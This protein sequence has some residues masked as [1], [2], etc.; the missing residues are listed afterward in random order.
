MKHFKDH[1]IRLL[2]V[3]GV[4][5]GKCLCAKSNCFAQGKHP[6]PFVGQQNHG[7]KNA[8]R[9]YSDDDFVG[10]NVGV[11]CGDGLLVV[12][13]DPR[14]N[15]HITWTQLTKGIELPQTWTVSTGGGG[16]HIY[17]RVP[18][19]R[20]IRSVSYEGVDFQYD[21]KYVIA[22]PSTHITGQTYDWV[23]CEPETEPIADCPKEILDWLEAKARRLEHTDLPEGVTGLKPTPI[24]A[25]EIRR[26]LDK[27]SPKIGYDNWLGVGMG[28][29]A[30]GLPNAFDMWD[31]WSR[32]DLSQYREGETRRKWA[33]FGKDN[34]R[35]YRFIFWLAELYQIESDNDFLSEWNSTPI[36]PPTPA[37][38]PLEHGYLLSSLLDMALDESFI[39]IEEFALASAL[40]ILSASVQGSYRS[41]TNAPLALY[42]WCAAPAGFGK[43]SYVNFTKSVVKDIHKALLP[44][45]FGSVGGLRSCLLAF[46]SI[47]CVKDEWHD[48]FLSFTMSHNEYA[49]ALGQDYKILYNGPLELDG[50]AIKASIQPP[51]SSPMLGLL[52]FSTID[53]LE[54]CAA[55]GQ[56]LVSGLGSR[57]L[58]WLCTTYGEMNTPQPRKADYEKVLHHLREYHSDGL[59]L[60][61]KTSGGSLEE[62]AKVQSQFGDKGKGVIKHS[63]QMIPVANLTL[64][65]AAT[66]FWNEYQHQRHQHTQKLIKEG[67]IHF[68][69]VLSRR[70]QTVSR[71]ASLRALSDLRKIVT[72]SDIQYADRLAE[73]M[74]QDNLQFFSA[75]SG[76]TARDDEMIA[77]TN[78]VYEI[79]RKIEAKIG[80]PLAKRDFMPFCHM[81]QQVLDPILLHLL[82]E[83]RIR[84]LDRQ[85][86]AIYPRN[87][88]YGQ[89]FTTSL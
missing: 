30:S 44:P 26:I 69:S 45:T 2:R 82:S 71:L 5:D 89:R 53:G 52:G 65:E 1:A 64:N 20:A 68:A 73:K 19:D 49:K 75:K 88:E 83:N 32:S 57:F 76:Q 4:S 3:F 84:I 22:P 55:D 40:Q 13:I 80:K 11:A 60:V 66:E 38:P 56:F 63:P 41:F 12:D 47:C 81:S 23:D 8:R 67:E 27:L 50:I 54:R 9:E 18:Q 43:D 7:V 35:S 14:N 77:K 33:T 51:I 85:G 28:L 37:E 15:G 79:M 6:A 74:F 21:G 34:G 59:T 10:Y 46:N 25:I 48:E 61:G 70:A 42:Q 24:E 58:F 17:Y 36:A 87:V 62:L 16:T 31:E 72:V 39:R 29:H 86:N 78:R